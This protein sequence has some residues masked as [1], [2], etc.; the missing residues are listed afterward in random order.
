VAEKKNWVDIA[1]II[2]VPLLIAVIG[3]VYTRVQWKSDE[4]RLHLDRDIGYLKLLASEKETEQQLGLVFVAQRKRDGDFSNDLHA[5]LTELAA[6]PPDLTTTQAAKQILD[7]RRQ[8]VES[9]KDRNDQTS[10]PVY[11]Q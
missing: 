10:T 3:G 8:V 7:E 9:I 6:G 5:M 2:L 4:E 1:G 11:I